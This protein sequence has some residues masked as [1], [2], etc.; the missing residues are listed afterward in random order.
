MHFS[1]P[2]G[3]EKKMPSVLVVKVP[4]RDGLEETRTGCHLCFKWHLLG[5]VRSKK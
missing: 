4:F 3:V 1:F 2:L 5:A